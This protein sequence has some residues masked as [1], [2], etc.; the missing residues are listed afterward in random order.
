MPD[1]AVCD[2][3]N[4]Q[5][6]KGGGYSFYSSAAIGMLGM[7]HETGNMLLCESC[8][9]E[10]LNEKNWAKKI[11]KQREMTG[12]DI[13][14]NPMALLGN[15]RSANGDSIVTLCKRH[16]FTPEQAKAEARGFALLWWG[17][18]ETERAAVS[19]LAAL[20]WKSGNNNVGKK[21]WQFWK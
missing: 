6:E 15:I 13:L 16:G 8:T 10:I 2:Q 18:P 21:W 14:A 3:C 7:S 5:I 20:F 9:S 17:K 12:A 1:H 11:P 4:G 19:N